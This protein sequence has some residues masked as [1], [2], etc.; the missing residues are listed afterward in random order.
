VP[1]E[2]LVPH[3]R[4]QA[5]HVAAERGHLGGAGD[6]HRL[7][8]VHAAARADVPAEPPDRDGDATVDPERRE[9]DEQE[10]DEDDDEL[11]LAQAMAGRERGRPV[12]ADE[13]LP[14]G[15][16]DR[17]LLVQ[18][19]LAVDVAP[20]GAARTP[21]IGAGDRR[22]EPL[23]PVDRARE[24]RLSVRARDQELGR[25]AAAVDADE[26]LADG[27]EGDE[28]GDDAVARRRRGDDERAV[29]R[30]RVEHRGEEDGARLRPG[31]PGRACV[32]AEGVLAVRLARRA[33]QPCRR[34]G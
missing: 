2:E 14:A 29:A 17:R 22:A 5:V 20:L 8:R 28:R 11:P 1:A 33:R 15:A 25:V 13:E 31:E 30:G 4:D 34:P 3:R 19:R 32:A 26:R 16:R 24:D 18:P 10:P 21:E 6:W 12:L 27:R 23:V 9:R 7:R